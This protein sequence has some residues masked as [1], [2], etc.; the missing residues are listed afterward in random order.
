MDS[1]QTFMSKLDSIVEE[2]NTLL[3]IHQDK[4]FLIR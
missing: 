1:L 2:Y 3:S 4:E